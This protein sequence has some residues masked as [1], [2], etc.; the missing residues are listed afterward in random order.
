[1]RQVLDNMYLTNNNRVAVMDGQVNLDD[2]L[3]NR[4]GGIVRTKSAPSQVMMPLQ[5]QALTQQAFPLLQYL[6]TI[7]EERSGI[8][9]YTKVWILIH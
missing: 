5:N 2:L 7:K 8:T 6:D 9:K 1:M 4:P 3:T